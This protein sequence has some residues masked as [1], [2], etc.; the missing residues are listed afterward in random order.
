M[1][2]IML[3]TNIHDEDCQRRSSQ[4]IAR[5]LD[6]IREIRQ[7]LDAHAFFERIDRDTLVSM[8]ALDMDDIS[9]SCYANPDGSMYITLS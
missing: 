3:G 5:Q 7:A 2:T 6:N 8:L 1:L 4:E 9:I